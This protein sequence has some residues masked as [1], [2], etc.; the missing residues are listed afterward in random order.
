MGH[1]RT[2]GQACS[3]DYRLVMKRGMGI[4]GLINETRVVLELDT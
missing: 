3:D 2:T 4:H 1:S